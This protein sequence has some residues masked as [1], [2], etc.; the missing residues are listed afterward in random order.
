MPMH[1]GDRSGDAEEKPKQIFDQW[2]EVSTCMG[3]IDCYLAR[4]LL[5]KIFW[6]VILTV[7]LCLTGWQV[8]MSVASFVG[9]EPFQVTISNQLQKDGIDFPNVT[10]C[11]YNRI[12][13]SHIEKHNM[14][15]ELL[16][17]IFQ[18]MPTVAGYDLPAGYFDKNDTKTNWSKLEEQAYDRYLASG[19]FR[20]IFEFF[21]VHGHTVDETFFKVSAGMEKI[22]LQDLQE[23]FT[24]Y[25][26]CWKINPN[27]KQTLPGAGNALQLI[28]NPR[29]DEYMN[30][31][32][33]NYLE[34]GM[35]LSF[36]YVDEPY[37]PEPVIVAPGTSVSISL[38]TT[39]HTIQIPNPR[40][41]KPFCNSKPELKVMNGTMYD[42]DLQILYS[43]NLQ[44]KCPYVSDR[45]QN[46]SCYMICQKP[47]TEFFTVRAT[48][49]STKLISDRQRNLMIDLYR[50]GDSSRNTENVTIMDQMFASFIKADIYFSDKEISVSETGESNPLF[51]FIGNI[52][53]QLGLWTGI[54]I[55]TVVQC[56]YYIVICLFGSCGK[57]R[58]IEDTT[59]SYDIL[60]LEWSYSMNKYSLR[61]VLDIF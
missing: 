37:I 53:G 39:K 32:Y 40:L 3:V 21:R 38:S 25:G 12:K 11:N 48:V 23:Q 22:D 43:Y 35:V 17:Y 7:G 51:V 26:K 47:C 55:M 42:G 19:G 49:T 10:V 29:L 24:L 44:E 34:E 28:M 36:T 54:S 1:N 5:G 16:S 60:A 41:R 4:S 52:G 8:S 13:Q 15:P 14:T 9:S 30:I 18:L 56:F 2:C 57:K 6:I 61:D 46:D 33:N 59:W 20:N 58:R 45:L 50:K 27:F 31:I